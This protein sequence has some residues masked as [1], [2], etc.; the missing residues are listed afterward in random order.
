[1]DSKVSAN[2]GWCEETSRPNSKSHITDPVR[3]YPCTDSRELS[4]GKAILFLSIQ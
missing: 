3:E 1:N 4:I 2:G